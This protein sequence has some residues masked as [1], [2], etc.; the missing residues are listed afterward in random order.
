VGMDWHHRAKHTRVTIELQQIESLVRL[1]VPHDQ[2][3]NVPD[4]LP[5]IAAGWPRVLS[6]LKS[7]LETGKPLPTW[8]GR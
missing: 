3:D 4:M 8:A 7:L 1:A 6:S 2:F 5:K